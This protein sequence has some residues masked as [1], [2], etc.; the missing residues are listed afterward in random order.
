MIIDR[1]IRNRP[2]SSVSRRCR[3][4][5][6]CR[7]CRVSPTWPPL[8]DRVD[9][10]IR[11]NVP[12]SYHMWLFFVHTDHNKPTVQLQICLLQKLFLVQTDHILGHAL[13]QPLVMRGA[14][15][16]RLGRHDLVVR[17]VVCETARPLNTGQVELRQVFPRPERIELFRPEHA[18]LLLQVRR[19]A[20]H[21]LDQFVHV[22]LDLLIGGTLLFGKYDAVQKERRP[23]PTPTHIG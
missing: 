4:V 2:T 10:I 20:P 15:Q 11:R 22:L 6:Q 23:L 17:D 3:S 5:D 1:L 14:L 21:L 19:F 12:D 9:A 18:D 13:D 16:K 7:P 8:V